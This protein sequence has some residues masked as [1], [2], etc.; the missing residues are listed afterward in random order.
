M[1]AAKQP[2]AIKSIKPPTNEAAPWL[3][4]SVLSET[5]K[6]IPTI[7]KINPVNAQMQVHKI[8]H[9]EKVFVSPMRAILDI[10]ASKIR[11]LGLAQKRLR[12]L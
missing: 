6:L 8:I 2:A 7:R 12:F 3:E 1:Y 5:Q 10:C 11:F 9:N 4:H